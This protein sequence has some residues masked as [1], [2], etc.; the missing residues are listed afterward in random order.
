MTFQSPVVAGGGALIRNA[1][2]SPNY[3]A[4]SAGWSINKDGSA[5]F[6]SVTLRGTL[7]VNK[8]SDRIVIGDP[9]FANPTITAYKNGIAEPA[10][11]AGQRPLGSG[12]TGWSMSSAN[13]VGHN[14]TQMQV[15]E[16]GWRILKGSVVWFGVDYLDAG[17]LSTLNNGVQTWL[18][19]VVKGKAYVGAL[20]DSTVSTTT[21]VTVTSANNVNVPVIAGRG[22][23]ATVRIRVAGSVLNDRVR[24]IVAD[25][26]TQVGQEYLHRI[27]G[28]TGT[29]VDVE[30]QVYWAAAL[31][32]TIANLNLRMNLGSGTGVI[33]VR[34]E[35]PN[36]FMV[37]EEIG[38]A[39]VISGI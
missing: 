21:F 10:T 19:V 12:V 34:V 14:R 38:E 17:I 31:T 25:G 20:V 11:L 16:D 15:D 1:I 30:F 23:R 37:V 13:T 6:S 22:Y 26:T 8:A 39:T 33:T 36:Y 35:N 4:G 18:P 24:F 29:F 32:T 3:V 9:A 5:E 27:T 28:A 7:T 2:H